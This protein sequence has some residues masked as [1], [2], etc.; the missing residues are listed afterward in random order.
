MDPG[1]LSE[2]LFALAPKLGGA[3]VSD[4]HR[5]SGGASQE[6]WAFRLQ[7][8]GGERALILRRRPDGLAERDER[9]VSLATEA[10][11]IRAVAARGAPTPAI[12]HVAAARDGLGEAYIMERVEG[13][14][15]GRR[16]VRDAAF[17]AIRPDLARRCGEVLAIIHATPLSALPALTASTA[18]DELDRYEAIYRQSGAARPIFELA[19]RKLRAAA[20]PHEQP[21]L[22]HGDFRNGNLMISPT[23]G[24]VA[25]LDWELAHLGDAASDLGWLCVNSWRFG[26]YD[27]PAGGFGSY[28]ALIDGYRAGGGQAVT[29]ETVKYWQM[30]GSLKW[31]VMCLIMY[32]AFASGAD[33]GVERAM[34]GRRVSETELDLVNLI[35]EG[36]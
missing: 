34:I 15:L 33:P 36:R 18:L 19:L 31:G 35:E 7:A 5:L 32:G 4:L 24:L 21:V 26:A 25:V 1:D 10:A 16:I 17:A 11:L 30:L 8:P 14:T 22:L 3:G 12:L 28:E 29:V 9:T 27:K 23:E 2:A 20:P 6:T 13:E